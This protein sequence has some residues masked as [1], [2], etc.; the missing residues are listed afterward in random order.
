MTSYSYICVMNSYQWQQFRKLI[1]ESNIR[2][3]VCYVEKALL[4][5]SDC[6]FDAFYYSVL[7]RIKEADLSPITRNRYIKMFENSRDKFIILYC[8]LNNML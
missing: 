5:N 4:Q 8:N 6:E 7:D 2:L 3:P 1:K